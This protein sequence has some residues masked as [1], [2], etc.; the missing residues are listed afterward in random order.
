MWLSMVFIYLSVQETLHC[1]SYE[2]NVI[3]ISAKI[4]IQKKVRL[5]RCIHLMCILYFYT[6]KPSK[7]GYLNTWNL[8]FLGKVI[9]TMS[10]PIIKLPL[11]L[12]SNY[13]KG[14]T[15]L[16]THVNVHQP[17]QGNKHSY[18]QCAE[19]IYIILCPHNEMEISTAHGCILLQATLIAT[20]E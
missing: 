10:C 14:I 6:L 11:T 12:V 9:L 20:E 4:Q 8:S 16:F 5:L 3:S 15:A 7:I 2:L 13:S 17:I 18:P 1:N 19:G